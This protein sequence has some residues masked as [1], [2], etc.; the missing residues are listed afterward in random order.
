VF[1]RVCRPI[2]SFAAWLWSPFGKNY[3]FKKKFISFDKITVVCFLLCLLETFREPIETNA[4]IRNPC[5]DQAI[6]ICKPLLKNVIVY[7][8]CSI[9]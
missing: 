9:W 7:A 8:V 3:G 6:S 1:A 4:T 5:T 2:G